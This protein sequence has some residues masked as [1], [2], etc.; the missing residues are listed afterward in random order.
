MTNYYNLLLEFSFEE[1]LNVPVASPDTCLDSRWIQD[2]GGD[3]F[4]IWCPP[5][6]VCTDL[7]GTKYHQKSIAGLVPYLDFIDYFLYQKQTDLTEYYALQGY[8]ENTE[9][10]IS[11]QLD[12]INLIEFYEKQILFEADYFMDSAPI[13]KWM[14]QGGFL[15]S[16]GH[17]RQ[18]YLLRKGYSLLPLRISKVDY[19]KWCN[20]PKEAVSSSCQRILLPQMSDCFWESRRLFFSYQSLLERYFRED[21]KW[22]VLVESE[23][24]GGYFGRRFFDIDVKSLIFSSQ[25]ELNNLNEVLRSYFKEGK[26]IIFVVGEKEEQ[27]KRMINKL[28]KSYEEQYEV[29]QVPYFFEPEKE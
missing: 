3:Y 25:N 21:G 5:E 16:D 10:L 19:Q 18:A 24:F 11:Y 6:L 13:G 23:T 26:Y 28:G 20:W 8:S 1:I 7:E 9:D 12:R 15:L 17:H 4:K 14:D 22:D 2:E 27:Q 29:V